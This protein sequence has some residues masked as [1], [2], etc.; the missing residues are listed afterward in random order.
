MS[1]GGARGR[2]L[3]EEVLE[4]VRRAVRRRVR[5]IRVLLVA[6]AHRD[7]EADGDAAAAR[8]LFAEHPDPRREHAAPNLRVACR[9]EREFGPAE[10]EVDGAVHPV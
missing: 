2:A 3:E 5:G 1:S 9:R 7:P 6:G 8:H 4:E 10:W